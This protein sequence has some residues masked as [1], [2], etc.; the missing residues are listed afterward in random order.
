[1]RRL[2]M[3]AGMCLLVGCDATSPSEDVLVT[4]TTSVESIRPGEPVAIKLTIYNRGDDPV[5]ILVDGC[6]PPYEVLDTRGVVVGPGSRVCIAVAIPPTQLAPGAT[7]E[8][9]TSWYGDSLGVSP[10]DG[11]NY[12]SPGLYAIRPRVRVGEY[13]SFK[14]AYGTALGVLVRQ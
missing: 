12:L 4:G 1:M 13:R 11:W 14:Y 8:Q 6:I 2:V 5:N 3:L 10:A 7:M 9:T